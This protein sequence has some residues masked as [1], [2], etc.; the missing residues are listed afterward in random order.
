G[1]A[2]LMENLGW[3]CTMFAYSSRPPDPALVGERW[4]DMWMHRLENIPLLIENWLKH[5]RR[6]HYWQHGS[7]CED[8]GAITAAVFAVGGWGD[9]YSNTIPRLLSGLKAP[10]RGLTGPWVHKYPHNAVPCPRIGFLQECLRWWDRWLKGIDT[11]VMDEPLYRA[12]MLET[13]RPRASYEERAGR[14]IAE[15][16]WPSPGIHV[17]TL[18]L[19]AGRLDA[20][21]APEH[22]LTLCSPQD[23]GTAGGEYCAMW[24]GPE[25][26][27]DQQEDDARSLVFDTPP[28]AER[29]EIFGAPMLTLEMAANRPKAFIAVRLCD[30]WPEG[31]S[32]RVTYGVLNLTHR[33]SHEHPTLLEPGKRYRV[34]VQLDDIAYAFAPGHRIRVAVSTAYWPMVWPSS[35]PVTLQL[36]TGRSFLNLPVRPPREQPS[37]PFAQPESTRTM[38]VDILRPES[39]TRTTERDPASG[40]SIVHII[41]DFGEHRIQA[42]GL[43]ISEV[44]RETYRVHSDDPLS[45]RA[46]IH[47][48]EILYRDDWRVRTETRTEM[49][50]D[51]ENFVIRANLE[52][53][54][55]KQQVFARGWHQKISRDMT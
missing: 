4:R 39:H 24:L 35:E 52:A 7:V 20:E 18:V 31:D 21:P 41:D 54:E 9:A 10:T 48:T 29:A 8:Y 55:G 13:A 53:Y 26:P 42:H 17:N 32:T 46:N 30:V 11:G 28:L 47:W 27:T 50:A 23:T 19:N 51:H 43:T 14:W 49:W 22:V 44:A 34:R 6:D 5:Q 25:G 38:A 40:D 2:L 1:G 36:Y 12:Y 45:A 15:S 37:R 3:A 16:T 33:D